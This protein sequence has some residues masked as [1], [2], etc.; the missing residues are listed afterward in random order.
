MS[1]THLIARQPICNSSLK[2]VAYELLYRMNGANNNALIENQDSAT[3][4]V[5]LAAYNDLSITDV[6]GKQQAFVNFTSNI[7]INNLPPLSPKQLV[8]ELLEDQEVTPELIKA[9]KKLRSKGY[10]IALDDFCLTKET[11]SLIECA[12]IIKV[13]V[14]DQAPETWE[15]YIPKLKERG[16]LMLAEKVETYEVYE[17]CKKLGFELFQGYF[18]AKPKILSGK[19]MS[20]NSMSVLQLISKLN[21]PEV[22][23]DDIINTISADVGLSYNL[24][25]TLNSGMY[26]HV[27][28]VD[29]VR[30]A[31]VT[32]GLN[33]LRNWINLLALGS[34]D[35]KPSIVLETAMI[36]AKMCE[37]LGG[38]ITGKIAPEGYFTV[39]LFSMTDAFFD[40]PLEELI[41]KLALSNELTSALLQHKGD[42]GKILQITAHYQ[43]DKLTKQDLNFLEDYNITNQQLTQAYLNSIYWSKEQVDKA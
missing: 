35:N 13:D 36:R 7:I 4:D 26:A 43:E 19:K 18:F 5:L 37:E 16:I 8:I 33:N 40:T 21:M 27:N 32:L 6:I 9:L 22:D 12:D 38:I 20:R 42:K 25:R 29:S 2:V 10:K 39:G 15:S 31:A 1:H 23:Y 34:L 3:I 24:L 30:H 17:Q 41:K 14:L 11:L 28:K